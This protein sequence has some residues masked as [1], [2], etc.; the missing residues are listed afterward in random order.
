L[1]IEEQKKI[2]NNRYC[3]VVQRSQKI[4]YNS[5]NDFRRTNFLK[6]CR[7]WNVVSELIK[8]EFLFSTFVKVRLCQRLKVFWKTFFRWIKVKTSWILKLVHE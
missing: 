1:P 7:Y 6:L 3:Y 8:K 5:V 2:T 4:I